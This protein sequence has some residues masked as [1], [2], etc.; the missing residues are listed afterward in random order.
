MVRMTNR[1]IS[2]YTRAC[3]TL[4]TMHVYIEIGTQVHLQLI[5]KIRYSHSTSAYIIALLSIIIK[6]LDVSA[7]DW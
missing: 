2:P 7:D 4:C 1:L 5:H 6:R 3:A